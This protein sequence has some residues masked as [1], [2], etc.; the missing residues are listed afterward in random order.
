MT[1]ALTLRST[2]YLSNLAERKVDFLALVLQLLR[3]ALVLM[4]PKIL[5]L[6]VTTVENLERIYT[7]EKTE[8]M[9]RVGSGQVHQHLK[10]DS[11]SHLLQTIFCCVPCC[12]E[13]AGILRKKS[14]RYAPKEN[15]F[16]RAH[17]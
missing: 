4:R 11:T 2:N 1:S 10:K 16:V 14:G 6:D 9:P 13:D 5:V 12:L 3:L 15:M 7:C 8:A 17:D